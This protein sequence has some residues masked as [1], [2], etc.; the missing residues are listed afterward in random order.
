MRKFTDKELFDRV[1]NLATFRGFPVGMLDV[2]VRSA[3][4]KFDEFDDRIFTYECFGAEKEPRFLMA[5]TGTTNAGSFGLSKFQT[6][7]PLGCAVLCGDAI[8]LESHAPGLHRG[9]PGYVQ[10][11]GF[12]YTRDND[13]DRR[14]RNYGKIYT[15]VILANRHRAGAFSR[16][17]VNWSVGCIVNQDE[18]TFLKWLRAM[19]KRKLSVAILNEF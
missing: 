13:R 16:L 12:P 14:A 18:S 7:N 3:A 15:D 4:D 11:K 17:I 10:V 2:C 19:N 5:A 1:A 9:K 8:V 6:Y